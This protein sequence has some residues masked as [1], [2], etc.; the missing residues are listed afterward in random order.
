MYNFFKRL[1]PGEEKKI[2]LYQ[3]EVPMIKKYNLDQK[4]EELTCERV[5]LK[6][7]GYLIINVTEALTAIDINSGKAI[8]EKNIEETALSTNL[9]ACQEIP[10][11]LK[12]RNLGGLI[13]VDFIDLM[14]TENRKLVEN[15]IRIG[16][17]NDKAKVQ[18]TKLSPFGLM[19]ISRQR[20]RSSI[21][22]VR[23]DKCNNCNGTGRVKNDLNIA[24]EIYENLIIKV[25]KTQ[26]PQNKN[27]KLIVKVECNLNIIEILVNDFKEKILT[28]E[29]KYNV[30]LHFNTLIMRKNDTEFSVEFVPSKDSSTKG[31]KETY[32][33][34]EEYR[35]E[36]FK[37]KKF[38]HK[39]IKFFKKAVNNIIKKQ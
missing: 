39:T 20:I 32:F 12:L 33:A 28:I 31:I 15:E 5:N 9:E 14:N 1:I 17:E 24:N 34:F 22:E 38:I 4:I 10:R 30:E 23:L 21:Y 16:F 7:G 26:Q 2:K 13:V 25:S 29:K 6:S 36:I 37:Q 35:N 8:K 19:E 18:L 27:K 3:E 11:Q